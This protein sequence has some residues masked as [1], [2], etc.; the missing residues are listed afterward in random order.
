MMLAHRVKFDVFDENDLARIR[1]ENRAVD[2]I[3]D[4]LTITLGEKFE[5]SSS[6]D[7]RP[8]QSL[9]R[10]VFANC[11]QDLV[12]RLRQRIQLFLLEATRLAGKSLTN[13]EF[14]VAPHTTNPA[15]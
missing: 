3:L 4:T 8:S 14:R 6:S 12:K 10:C 9:A 5:R 15:N 1:I 2:D 11:F 7:W 13:F